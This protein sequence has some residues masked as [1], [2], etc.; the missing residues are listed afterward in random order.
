MLLKFF[1]NGTSRAY[2]RGLAEEFGEST[3][4]IRH[5]LNN[6]SRAGYL[7]SA[8]NGRTI[9]YRA[10]SEHP[11]YKDI[12]NLVHKYLG[13]DTII[14]NVVRKLGDLRA[15]YIVGDYAQGKDSGTIELLLVG[16]IDEAFLNS[17]V[18]K[19]QGLIHRTIKTKHISLDAFRE[20]DY[21]NALLVWA[22]E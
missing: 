22:A 12:K 16:E 13:I 14:E 17:L 11:L 18:D 1:T 19:A 2:L 21:P 5:E 20:Q 3:N 10:N 6:L 4:S 15:A 7:V 8:E 9:E